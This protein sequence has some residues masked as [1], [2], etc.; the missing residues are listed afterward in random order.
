MLVGTDGPIFLGTDGPIFLGTDGPIFLGTEGPIFLGTDGPIF[1]GTDSAKTVLAQRRSIH[2]KGQMYEAVFISKLT[3]QLSSFFVQ[4]FVQTMS[5]LYKERRQLCTN[6]VHTLYEQRQLCTNGGNFLRTKT[7]LYEQRQLC[8]NNVN[9]VRTT[10]TLYEQRQLCTS[11]A[12]KL[13]IDLSSL[14][15]LSAIPIWRTIPVTE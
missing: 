14:R 1:L 8:T 13:S 15:K 9:F 3:C 4:N 11:S 5:T 12:E 10:T 2:S 6:N 7:T